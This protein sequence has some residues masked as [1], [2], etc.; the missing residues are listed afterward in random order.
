MDENK[1][2]QMRIFGK[3]LLMNAFMRLL[4]YVKCS[5]IYKMYP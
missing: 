2:I 4:K 1:F 3:V 5:T